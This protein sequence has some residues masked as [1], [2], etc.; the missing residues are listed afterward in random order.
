MKW[1]VDMPCQRVTVRVRGPFDLQLS[2]AGAGSFLPIA[3][4]PDVLATAL[5]VDG[6]ST[7]ITVWQPRTHSSIRASATPSIDPLLLRR[8]T[9]WLAF[10]DLDL[11]SFYRHV[12]GHPIMGPVALSLNG[13]KP[14]R[15]ATLF[16]MAIIAITEQQLSLAAA[17]HIRERLVRRFGKLAG[18]VWRFPLPDEFARASLRT[19]TSCGL[20]RRKAEYVKEL[21][22]RVAGGSL[23]LD[24]LTQQSDS[25]IRE[26]LLA[27]RG[28]GEWSV[29][30]ILARGFGRPDAL[31]SEDVGLRRVIGYYLARGRMLTPIQME[32]ALAPFRPFRGLAAYYLAVHRR[33]R[34]PQI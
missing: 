4:P 12:S 9:K 11:H 25:R 26:Q 31:P 1:Q 33:L 15:P 23:D 30:Y 24:A 19:L 3:Q 22:A 2:L 13:L 27:L 14:L 32:R 16:E 8:I 18:T 21:A 5:D 29:Q 34:R 20:S 17:F 28:F 10:S 7:A 6:T